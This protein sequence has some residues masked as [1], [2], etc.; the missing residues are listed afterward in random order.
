VSGISQRVSAPAAP[1]ATAAPALAR[2]MPD[3]AGRSTTSP[4]AEATRRPGALHPRYA[5]ATPDPS[6]R[7]G[8]LLDVFA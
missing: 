3:D 5:G 4:D 8:T 6:G 7:S 2:R 1:A